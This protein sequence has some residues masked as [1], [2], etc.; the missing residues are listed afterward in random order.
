[1][2]ALKL[3]YQSSDPASCPVSASTVLR[4][5]KLIARQLG[6]L[7]R[8][9]DVARRL[10]MSSTKKKLRCRRETARCFM[11]LNISLI[12]SRSLKIIWN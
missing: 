1:M 12:H 6:H 4:L 3:S 2:H 7:P 8:P 9:A 10:A 11:P 5:Y